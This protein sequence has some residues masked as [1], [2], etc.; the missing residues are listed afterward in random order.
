[1]AEEACSGGYYISV[2]GD[3]IYGNR[4]TWTGSIGV[5]MELPNYKGLF[6]KLGIKTTYI[7]AG[8]NKTMGSATQ[9]LTAEQSKILQSIID[10]SYE[11]FVDVI[12]DG[13]KNMTEEEIRKAADGR[14]YTA[15]QAKDI[16]LI[17]DVKFYEEVKEDIYK[18]L[19]QDIEIYEE[20]SDE[21]S[22]LINELFSGVK[23]LIN[24]KEKSETE[25]V[26]E[27]IEKDGSG[28]PMYYAMP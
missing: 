2:A 8:K 27:M 13:R 22:K 16:G 26:L 3:K 19:G 17:D 6:D 5:Y 18:D 7:K 1:M 12:V 28:V 21:L 11:Q 9:D 15:K 23:S 14:I 20:E 10:E 25:K 4:N 24:S